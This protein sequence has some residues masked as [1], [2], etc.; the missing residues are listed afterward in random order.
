MCVVDIVIE[1]FNTAFDVK[2]YCL[3]NHESIDT[4]NVY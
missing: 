1:N 2:I 4:L 3:L